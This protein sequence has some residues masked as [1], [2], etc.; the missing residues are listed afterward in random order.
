MIVSY[1][2]F[3][4]WLGEKMA[5]SEFEIE[6]AAM[7][8]AKANRTR[9]ARMRTSLE[10]FPSEANPVSVF[11]AGSPGAGKTEAS[12]ELLSQFGQVLRIDPDD[13]RSEFS[14]Y[15]GLNSRLFQ[16]AVTPLVERIVDLALRQRQS[17]LLDGTFSNYAVAEKNVQ[18]C[19]DRNR[20]VQILYVY[21]EPEFAWE[22]VKAREIQEG[23]LIPPESFVEQYF[24]AREVAQKIKQ[25]FAKK[26]QIDLLLKN[27]DGTNRTFFANVDNVDHHIPERFSREQ[28]IALTQTT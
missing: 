4:R 28:V 24:A 22:F 11:M 9:I 5:R 19:L 2:A 15:N 16:R 18:R 3:N 1:D 25:R 8:Y 12:I 7:A 17:F 10:L 6:E 14:D 27:N 26:V 13:L 20:L 23:R 21:Q